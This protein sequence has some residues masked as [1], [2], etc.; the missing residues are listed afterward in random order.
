MSSLFD[1]FPLPESFRAL[2]ESGKGKNGKGGGGEGNLSAQG[3]GGGAGPEGPAGSGGAP[4]ESDACPPPDVWDFSEDAPPE[5]W[6]TAFGEEA[7]EPHGDEPS[8]RFEPVPE[9]PEPCL[10]YTSPSPRD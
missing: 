9:E 1:D 6:A 10:L 8:P 2:G 7:S 3:P 5:D 4:G